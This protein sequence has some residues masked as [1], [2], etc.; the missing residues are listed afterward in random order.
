MR[1]DRFRN[2]QF[3]LHFIG[4]NIVN[5]K[6]KINRSNLK[7]FG[8][9]I[10]YLAITNLLDFLV[11][12]GCLKYKSTRSCFFNKGKPVFQRTTIIY[13]INIERLYLLYENLLSKKSLKSFK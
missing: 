2:F 4:A 3:L 1:K 11:L 5:G 13:N 10:H 9:S 6:V 8:K 12:E 7:I